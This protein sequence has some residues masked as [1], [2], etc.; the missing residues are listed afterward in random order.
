MAKMILPFRPDFLYVDDAPH[1]VALRTQLLKAGLD[2]KIQGGN[3][4][5]IFDDLDV[6]TFDPDYKKIAEELLEQ[7]FHPENKPQKPVIETIYK[8]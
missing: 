6:N 8:L 2:I 1:A 7:I 5:P 3:G 4:D